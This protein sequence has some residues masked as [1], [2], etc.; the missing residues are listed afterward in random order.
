MHIADALWSGPQGVLRRGVTLLRSKV[1]S[2]KVFLEELLRSK[3]ASK[4]GFLEELLRSKVDGTICGTIHLYGIH[5]SGRPP[6]AALHCCGG[7]RRPPHSGGWCHI[8][9]YPPCF[10]EALL[11]TPS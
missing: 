3:V 8:W 7:G 11:R 5:N 6:K 2:K 4:K 9:Y 10:L 1:A